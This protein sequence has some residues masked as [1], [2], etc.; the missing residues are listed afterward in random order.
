MPL[1]KGECQ[2]DMAKLC[3]ELNKNFG[4][5]YT[6]KDESSKQG[7]PKSGATSRVRL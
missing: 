4:Q 6:V 1:F 3:R 7:N 5:K 2:E